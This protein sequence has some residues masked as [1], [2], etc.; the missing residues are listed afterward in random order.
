MEY[1]SLK[2]KWSAKVNR[3]NPPSKLLNWQL[4]TWL[5]SRWLE[6]TRPGSTVNKTMSSKLNVQIWPFLRLCSRNDR[7]RAARREKHVNNLGC[8]LCRDAGKTTRSGA[9]NTDRIMIPWSKLRK[10]CHGQALSTFAN[11]RLW[12]F[13]HDRVNQDEVGSTMSN[14]QIGGRCEPCGR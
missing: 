11:V 9:M 8:D 13:M 4:P 10:Y 2:S 1:N 5:L 3:R 14:F 7:P 12:L 6:I